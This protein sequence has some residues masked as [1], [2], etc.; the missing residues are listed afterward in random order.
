VTLD[1]PRAPSVRLRLRLPSG[2]QV[3]SVRAGSRRLEV[4]PDGTVSL[5]RRGHVVLTAT[6]TT[7]NAAARPTS[8]H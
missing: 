5:P 4:D 6:A 8:L 1:L 3:L 2:T 7:S